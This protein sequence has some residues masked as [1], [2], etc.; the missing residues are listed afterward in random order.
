MAVRRLLLLLAAAAAALDERE[1]L[2]V[3]ACMPLAQ[4]QAAQ[5]AC[6]CGRRPLTFLHIPKTAGGAI[7]AAGLY[8]AAIRWGRVADAA[9]FKRG[10]A[11]SQPHD[12]EEVEL[13]VKDM[14]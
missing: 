5:E 8:Q 6:P 10:A 1:S 4:A 7:E 13:A 3:D 9:W 11:R 12:K 14:M 2:P